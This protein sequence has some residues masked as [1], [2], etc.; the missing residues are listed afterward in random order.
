M[1]TGDG[2][3]KSSGRWSFSE[4]VAPVFVEHARKSIPGYEEGHDLIC[5]ISDH[6]IHE[7][8]RCIDVGCSTGELLRKLWDRHAEKKPVLTGI[9]TETEM[10]DYAKANNSVGGISFEL[11]NALDQSFEECDFVV[12]NYVLQ[13]IRPQY[14]QE[15][16]DRIWNGL[17][18]GGALVLFEKVRGADSRFNDILTSCYWEFKTEQGFTDS[19]IVSKWRSLRGVLEPFTEAGNLGL[20]QRAGWTDIETIWKWGPFQGFLAIK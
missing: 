20:L 3:R 16:L 12:M 11:T 14:R 19:E 1:D 9:D 8:S 5:K 6:F 15:V 4:G 2:I 18:W 10:I 17:T 13:F 7:G